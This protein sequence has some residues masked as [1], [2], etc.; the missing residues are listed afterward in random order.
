MGDAGECAQVG[1]RDAQPHLCGSDR[2]SKSL[3]IIGVA[4]FVTKCI[5]HSDPEVEKEPYDMCRGGEMPYRVVAER[6]GQVL[7]RQLM[8]NGG[9]QLGQ[10]IGRH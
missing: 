10:L 2:G 8:L 6:T 1:R 5:R 7:R 9:E 4:E 3:K